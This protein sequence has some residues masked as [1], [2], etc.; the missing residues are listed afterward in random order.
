MNLLLSTRPSAR[1]AA[2]LAGPSAGRHDGSSGGDRPRAAFTMVEIALSLAIIGFALV[3][4]IGVLPTGMN[5]QK[6]NREETIIN[7]DANYWLQKIRF[8]APALNDYDLTNYVTTIIEFVTP[9]NPNGTV[10]GVTSSNVY[11]PNNPSPNF[12]LINS[13]RVIG[14]LSTPKYLLPPKGQGGYLSNYVV[15]YV[16]ALTGPVVDKP[17][18]RNPDVLGSAFSYRMVSE[19]VPHAG[20]APLVPPPGLGSDRSNLNF[21]ANLQ[22]NLYDVRLL[23]RWPLLPNGNTGA[24]RQTYRTVVAGQLVGVPPQKPLWYF[25]EPDSYAPSP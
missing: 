24:G 22:T 4:I 3:A 7:Q 9:V 1:K 25:L 10:A 13:Q 5:V 18:Q 23:F 2:P 15:A 14:L 16:R 19:V 20:F 12:R 8:G 17:P 6:E 11:T 21:V